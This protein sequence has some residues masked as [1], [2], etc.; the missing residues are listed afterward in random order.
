MKKKL[1]SM[2]IFFIMMA[3]FTGCS[4]AENYDRDG[5]KSFLDGNYEEAAVH[6]TAAIAENPNR[7]DYYIDYGMTLIKLGD[8]EEAFVQFD[9]AYMDKDMTIVKENNK[10]VHRGQGIAYYYLQQ[11]PEAIEQFEEALKINELSKLNMDILNYMGNSLM[12]IGS[13]EEAIETYTSLILI[14]EKNASVFSNRALCYKNLGDFEKSL[15]DYESAIT[16]EPNNYTFYFGKYYLLTEK[17]DEA[18]ATE[19]LT[20]A[21]EI[22]GTTSEDKYNQAKLHYFE[23]KYDLAITELSEGYVNGFTEAYYYIGEIYRNKKDYT[24]AIFYYETFIS[25]GEVLAP[26]VYNQIASCLIKSGDYKKA[27]DYLENGIAY[28]NAGAMQALKKNEIIA[29]E[30]LGKF[31]VAMEKLEEYLISYPKDSEALKEAEFIKTR[32]IKIVTEE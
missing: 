10:R 16:L 28:N 7:A 11:Y 26:N 5:K 4:S 1:L 3:M 12:T 15:M 8:Y 27:I 13:Y 9:R 19:V 14:N 20:Q 17:G 29:Y 32:L 22:V 25:E 18:G 2:G 6:F 30:S 23:E 31:D 24:K 21:S